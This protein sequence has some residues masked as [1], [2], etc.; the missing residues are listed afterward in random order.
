MLVAV[1]G[2]QMPAIKKPELDPRRPNRTY[3]MCD[4]PGCRRRLTMAYY[5][6]GCG[7]YVCD[8]CDEAEVFGPHEFD[9]HFNDKG[10]QDE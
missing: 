9:D 7:K 5:C 1:R 10:V 2:N 6:Y 3:Y 8:D 4:G